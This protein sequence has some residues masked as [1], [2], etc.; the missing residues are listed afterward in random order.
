MEQR[1]TAGLHTCVRHQLNLHC[2]INGNIC[3]NHKSTFLY[4]LIQPIHFLCLFMV[5]PPESHY[6]Y[7]KL[8]VCVQML[9]LTCC[10][11]QGYIQ[12]LSLSVC[13]DDL[14]Q[15]YFYCLIITHLRKWSRWRVTAMAKANTVTV[16]SDSLSESSQDKVE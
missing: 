14:V 7:V 10:S 8:L 15:L 13:M 4:V 1:N 11:L 9:K 2:L 6:K 5:S 16:C 12:K 3:L